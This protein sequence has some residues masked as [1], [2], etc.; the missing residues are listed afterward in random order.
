MDHRQV[1]S[2]PFPGREVGLTYALSQSEIMEL[3][4]KLLVSEFNN[5]TSVALVKENIG[6]MSDG[7][8]SFRAGALK[9]GLR[10]AFDL[11]KRGRLP[12]GVSLRCPYGGCAWY[13]A[14]VSY[15]SVGSNVYCPQCGRGYYMQCVGCGY[16]RTSNYASCQGCG[17]RFT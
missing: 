1:G 11:K 3:Q 13:N 14:R 6:Q 16:D 2:I 10:Q 5:P 15:S 12:P 4:C 8:L 9:V 17:K 7:S